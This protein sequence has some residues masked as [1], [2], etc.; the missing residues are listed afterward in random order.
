MRKFFIVLLMLLPS[1]AFADILVHDPCEDGT[2]LGDTVNGWSVAGYAGSASFVSSGSDGAPTARYGNGM[3]KMFKNGDGGANAD[4]VELIPRFQTTPSVRNNVFETTYWYGWS[5]YFPSNWPTFPS[6]NGAYHGQWH[7]APDACDGVGSTAQ[8]LFIE[9]SPNSD[10]FRLAARSNYTTNACSL[11]YTWT[12]DYN[13]SANLIE[14]S[15]N[16]IVI[17]VKFSYSG[18]GIL[19]GWLNGTQFI[20]LENISIGHNDV[21]GHYFKWGIYAGIDT[22]DNTSATFYLDEFRIGD[23][24]SSYEEVA[25]RGGPPDITAPDRTGGYPTGTL[26]AG[27]TSTT[28]GLETY[29]TATCKYGTTP[30]TAYESIVNTFSTTNAQAHSQ[31]ISGLTDGDT[32]TY[33]VR[34][35][36]GTNVNK[37]DYVISFSVDEAG[38]QTNLIGVNTLVSYDCTA[39]EA[40][41]IYDGCTDD[42]GACLPEVTGN[43]FEFIINLGTPY[44]GLT[45]RFFGDAVGTRV[46]K[47]LTVDYSLNGTDWTNFETD[48]NVYSS[49]WNES[50]MT[51]VVA[52]FIK[53]TVESDTGYTQFREMELFGTV[54]EG[55]P[56]TPSAAARVRFVRSANGVT[57]TPSENGVTIDFLP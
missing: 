23:E 46:S 40:T 56:P 50:A 51:D 30:E 37:T 54:Y 38:A 7:I 28:I 32:K 11:G 5:I 39:D 48:T 6:G 19:K 41:D 16:D 36:D 17:Q 27:T 43:S 22:D 15:W 33:Y 9:I 31:S 45:R 26:A 47:T 49:S 12:S 3:Y 53:V 55:S 25:P 18:T 42:V 13:Y 1:I 44:E 24:N 14:D 10:S 57:T 52:Q 20:N 2:L 21:V 34:C 29:E 8:P 4:R 35:T